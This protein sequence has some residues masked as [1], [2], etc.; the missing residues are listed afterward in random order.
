MDKWENIKEQLTTGVS[1]SRSVL[2]SPNSYVYDEVLE[3]HVLIPSVRDVFDNQERFLIDIYSIMR[4]LETQGV[5]N[6]WD[7]FKTSLTNKLQDLKETDEEYV[8]M[9]KYK[10]QVISGILKCI[11]DNT[12]G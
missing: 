11:E 9:F 5:S 4:G 8:S 6:K 1:Y 7:D 12:N 3:G 10:Q 2:N